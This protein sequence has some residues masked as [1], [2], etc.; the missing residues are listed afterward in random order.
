MVSGI[1]LSPDQLSRYMDSV[2]ELTKRPL[3]IN[4]LMPFLDRECVPV[5][6]A[7][8][9]V[10]EFFYGPPEPVLVETVHKEGALTA[11]QVGSKAEA[12]D[13][14]RAGCDFI[15]VQ[16]T[17][18]GGHVRGHVGLLP[19]LTEILDHV[20]V[21]VL[22]A[23]GI[24]TGRELAAVLA[25]G[26]DGARIGTRFVVSEESGAHPS[27]VQ[28]LVE[29]NAED[30]VITEAFSATWPNAPHRVLR[31]CVQAVNSAS[32][33]VVAEVQ[34]PSSVMKVPRFGSMAPTRSTT[35]N[36]QAMAMYAG[37]SVSSIRRVQPAKEIMREIIETAR[38]RLQARTE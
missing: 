17:E 1:R 38:R 36:I 30:T 4:F 10:V 23:G 6:A 27:Y 19:L 15:I 25:A 24:A 29:A 16:G 33:E 20:E 32:G 12:L 8:A 34:L 7:K 18:A 5:A 9:R 37:Q 13:A 3:G 28:A 22:A 26:A 35:G 11:W 2:R 14:V 21:P 31:S